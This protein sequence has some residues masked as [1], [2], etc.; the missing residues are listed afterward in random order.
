V[1]AQPKGGTE[2]RSLADSKTTA[3]E[4]TKKILG[5]RSIVRVGNTIAPPSDSVLPRGC[6]AHTA[7][8]AAF[9]ALEFLATAAAAQRVSSI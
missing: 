9:S 7:M 1:S 5:A 6:Q 4:V 2:E 8:E 3:K